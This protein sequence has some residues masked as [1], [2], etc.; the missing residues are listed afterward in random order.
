LGVLVLRYSNRAKLTFR[1]SIQGHPAAKI[2]CGKR[3]LG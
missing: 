2:H 3:A 1:R